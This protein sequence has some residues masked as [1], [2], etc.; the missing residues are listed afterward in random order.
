MLSASNYTK[1]HYCDVIIKTVNTVL[2]LPILTRDSLNPAQVFT[3]KYFTKQIKH[4]K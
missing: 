3:G 4:Q 1:L 2:L